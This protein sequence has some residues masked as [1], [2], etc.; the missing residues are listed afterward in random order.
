MK[1]EEIIIEVLAWCITVILAV[2]IVVT[3]IAIFE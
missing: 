1:K 3:V 2:M